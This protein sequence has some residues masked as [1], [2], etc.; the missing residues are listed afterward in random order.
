MGRALPLVA[1]AGVALTPLGCSNR[2][3]DHLT[4]LGDSG[5]KLEL[6]QRYLIVSGP[7]GLSTGLF[8]IDDDPDAGPTAVDFAVTIFD[9][10]EGDLPYGFGVDSAE[11]VLASI[12]TAISD[13]W[14][15]EHASIT[16]NVTA[17]R[18]NLRHANPAGDLRQEEYIYTEEG[19]LV[20]I[21]GVINSR[22]M[23]RDAQIEAFQLMTR[24]LTVAASDR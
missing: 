21:S 1:A 2:D 12:R 6:P 18:I 17:T 14:V 5:V 10:G 8:G 23:P 13:V 22:E 7:T 9:S 15:E 4:E 11:Q 3:Q 16:E 20:R 19:R 24:T